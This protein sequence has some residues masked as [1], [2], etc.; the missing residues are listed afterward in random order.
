MKI[1]KWKVKVITGYEKE[2]E[3]FCKENN[4]YYKPYPA[5]FKGLYKAECAKDKLLDT[6]HILATVEEM[7]V[8]TLS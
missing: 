1:D 4:I 8:V 2:F 3:Q 5:P 6:G 7:P